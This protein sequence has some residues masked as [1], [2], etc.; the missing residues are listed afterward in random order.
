[1]DR[2][3]NLSSQQQVPYF[4]TLISIWSIWRD[5]HIFSY[6]LSYHFS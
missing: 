6:P 5:Q 3:M 4:N 1:M 2:E